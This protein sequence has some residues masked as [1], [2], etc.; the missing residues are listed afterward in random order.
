MH[1][2]DGYLGPPTYG[3]L[4]AAMAGIWYAAAK[5]VKKTLKASEVPMLAL[6]AALS[7]VIM[8][9]N[10]PI[11]GGTTGHATGTALLAITLGP[12]AAVIAV[13]IAIAVQ[14]ILFGDGGITAYGANCFNMAF[15]DAMVSYI[16]FRLLTA[17]FRQTDGAGGGSPNSAVGKRTVFASALAAYAGINTA[18]FMCAMELGIQPILHR[19]PDGRP[20]YC[21]FPLKVTIP[22][23]MTGHLLA[24]GPLE[25]VFTALAV[26]W[27][28]KAYPELLRRRTA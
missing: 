2:P 7:F 3:S 4:W 10:V 20:L 5:K 16:V 28:G 13:S 14:A 9:F 23:M 8:M 24:F 19:A 27:L 17:G 26:A 25:A 15:T 6:G 22:A 18:A 12:W 1:I 21:P 11:A